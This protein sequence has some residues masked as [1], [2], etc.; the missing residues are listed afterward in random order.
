MITHDVATSKGEGYVRYHLVLVCRSARP[1][2]AVAY[3]NPEEGWGGGAKVRL[4]SPGSVRGLRDVGAGGA[5]RGSRRTALLSSGVLLSSEWV[6]AER[7]FLW[8]CGTFISMP[9]F[10]F[11]QI[12][13]FNPWAPPTLE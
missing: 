3:R 9:K 10:G 7:Y 12:P 8:V 11:Y 2:T 13:I 6:G 5:D 1:L 4:G